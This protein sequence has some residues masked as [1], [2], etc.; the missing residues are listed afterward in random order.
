MVQRAIVAAALCVCLVTATASAS[1]TYRRDT[2]GDAPYPGTDIVSSSRI[3]W[4]EDGVRWLRFSLRL[5]AGNTSVYDGRIRLDVDGDGL[6]DARV[7]FSHWDNGPSPD[8]CALRIDGRSRRGRATANYLDLNRFRCTIRRGWLPR[9][10][11]IGWSVL[12]YGSN[13]DLTDRAP[14][15]GWYR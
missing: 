10:G 6:I 5:G 15:S 12:L 13:G 7:P 8:H 4:R 1:T 3:V 14:D 11:A 2:I 9:H